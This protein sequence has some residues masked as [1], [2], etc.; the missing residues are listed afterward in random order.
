MMAH[1]KL[2]RTTIWK[3]KMHINHPY[4]LWKSANFYHVLLQLAIIESILFKMK[5]IYTKTITITK[6]QLTKLCISYE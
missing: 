2:I 3:K 6:Q 4:L 1:L 5:L